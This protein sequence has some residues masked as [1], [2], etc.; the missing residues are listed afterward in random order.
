MESVTT[1]EV[2][3]AMVGNNSATRASKSVA[4]IMPENTR[5]GMNIIVCI[6][7]ICILYYAARV[8]KM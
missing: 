8:Q 2:A 7:I 6:V 1:L 5:D 4:L 3:A